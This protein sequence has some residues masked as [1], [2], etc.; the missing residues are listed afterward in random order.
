M[1]LKQIYNRIK[2]SDNFKA[3]KKEHPK[4]FLNYVFY[5]EPDKTL[6]FGL[7]DPEKK[8]IGVFSK[9]NYRIEEKALSDKHKE[10]L[11]EEELIF[12]NLLEKASKKVKEKYTAEFIKK[13]CMLSKQ[14]NMPEWRFTFLLKNMKTI[15]VISD[16]EGNIKKEE[17]IKLFSFT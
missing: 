9:E 16:L 3:Y 1:E 15:F 6:E 11:N 8:N 7:Y 5:V 13:I 17:E 10:E 4:A 14:K 2:Q 12:N